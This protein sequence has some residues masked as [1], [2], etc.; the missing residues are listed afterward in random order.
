MGKFI[1]APTLKQ[2]EKLAGKHSKRP[3]SDVK[4][5]WREIV[6]EANAYGEVIVTNYNRP[7]VVVVSID[8][9]SKLKTNAVAHDPLTTLRAEFD[10]ELAVL[11][12]AKTPRKLREVFASSPRQLANAANAAAARRRR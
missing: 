12:D 10:R 11:R 1:M 3:V 5:R 4:A 8:H 6:E 7:E 9:Y 2:L